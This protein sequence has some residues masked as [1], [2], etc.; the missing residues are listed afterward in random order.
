MR[1]VFIGPSVRPS[2][3]KL[4]PFIIFGMLRAKVA[5]LRQIYGERQSRQYSTIVDATVDEFCCYR[6]ID[7]NTVHVA[8]CILLSAIMKATQTSYRSAVTDP[9]TQRIRGHHPARQH[10]HS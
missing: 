9:N 8:Y 4:L 3:Q 1:N 2:V 6:N 7:I 5:R 10:L